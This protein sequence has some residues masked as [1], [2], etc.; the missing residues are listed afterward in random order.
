MFFDSCLRVAGLTLP[1]QRPGEWGN[2]RRRGW[3][4]WCENLGWAAR[5][6]QEHGSAA[7]WPGLTRPFLFGGRGPIWQLLALDAEL[8]NVD[9][10]LPFDVL[11]EADLQVEQRVPILLGLKEL[12]GLVKPFATRDEE[13]WLE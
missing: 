2:E 8:H 4:I 13:D 12:G 3:E 5:M 9:L 10:T 6:A 7:H 1:A 11:G